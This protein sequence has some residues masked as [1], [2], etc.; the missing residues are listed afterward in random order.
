M[1]GEEVGEEIHLRGTAWGGG[2]QTGVERTELRTEQ[3][4]H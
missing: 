2:T 3:R 4:D 1:R